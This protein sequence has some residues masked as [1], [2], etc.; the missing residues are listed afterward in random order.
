MALSFA[1]MTPKTPG[2]KL[3]FGDG[4]PFGAS[5]GNADCLA[6]QS[7]F[8]L[9]QHFL[10]FFPLPQGQGSF[11]EIII[12]PLR[13]RSLRRLCDDFTVDITEMESALAVL[14]NGPV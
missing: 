12:F 4:F 6:S 2:K 11:R 10:N 14:P 9:M 3:R 1:S 5:M 7:I 13:D 8:L